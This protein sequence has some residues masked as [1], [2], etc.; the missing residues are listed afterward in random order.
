MIFSRLGF[1]LLLASPLVHAQLWSETS[2]ASLDITQNNLQP[3]CLDLC[4]PALSTI[5][6]ALNR[7]DNA[8]SQILSCQCAG[9]TTLGCFDSQVILD[10]TQPVPTCDSLSI[11]AIEDCNPL[12]SDLVMSMKAFG[13]VNGRIECACDDADIC[14]DD[15][16]CAQI[17]VFPGSAAEDCA[18]FCGPNVNA[19]ETDEVEFAGGNFVANKAQ[20]HLRVGC[21]CGAF[22][23]CRDSILFSD[24]AVLDGCADD[25]GISSDTACQEHC[26]FSGFTA[27]AEFI[28]DGLNRNCTCASAE[29]TAVVCRDGTEESD[30]EDDETP[31]DTNSDDPNNSAASGPSVQMILAKLGSILSVIVLFF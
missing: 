31:D 21:K 12:C 9:D 6:D 2:C 16:T 10:R 25:L 29:G 27:E 3:A 1:L 14:S 5:F 7:T 17:Q 28:S 23:E 11:E 24:L 15:P 30:G 8:I 18:R 20:T 22:E 13:D 4:A 19:V 26:D